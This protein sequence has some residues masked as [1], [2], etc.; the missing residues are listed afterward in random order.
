MVGRL[1]TQQIS[2][3]Y[4]IKVGGRIMTATL[5]VMD[6]GRFLVTARHG[7]TNF[8]KDQIEFFWQESWHPIDDPKPVED[9]DTD[10]EYDVVALRISEKLP[11]EPLTAVVQRKRLFIGQ[12][13]FFCV[14]PLSLYTDSS[15]HLGRP[16]ALAKRA[17]ISG[18]GNTGSRQ[19]LFLD[20]MN[21][22]GFSGGPFLA[23]IG[24]VPVLAGIMS[25][26]KHR[27][28]SRLPVLA[29]ACHFLIAFIV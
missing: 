8:P 9:P 15:R 20:A 4:R 5:L 14:F 16:I 10:F 27:N 17:L 24:T 6:E 29:R 25:S 12:D 3:A 22:K 21:T 13:A 26:Y 18:F 7:L 1:T 23:V 28:I 19:A 2:M 11:D